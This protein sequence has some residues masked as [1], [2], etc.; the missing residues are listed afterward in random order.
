[1]GGTAANRITSGVSGL[2]G[3]SLGA[4]GG[5]QLAQRDT[6]TAAST[7]TPTVAPHHHS[8]TSAKP[9]SSYAPNFYGGTGFFYQ[10]PQSL[11]TTDVTV[12]ITVA[13]TTTATSSLTGTSQNIPPAAMVNFLIYLGA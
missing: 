10:T 11:D 13:T 3:A 6:I 1:M 2:S 7:S 12:G 9:S 4:A 8:L 5:S